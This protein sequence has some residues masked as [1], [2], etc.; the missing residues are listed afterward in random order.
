MQGWAFLSP[1]LQASTKVELLPRV[2]EEQGLHSPS[3]KS[4]F[5]EKD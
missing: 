1:S 2:C 4:T 5:K 3:M